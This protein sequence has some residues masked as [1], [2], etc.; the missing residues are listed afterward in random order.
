MAKKIQNV[1]DLLKDIGIDKEFQK[2]VE[3]VVQSRVISRKLL[4]LRNKTG[5]TQKELANKFK[6]TQSTISKIESKK[7]ADLTLGEIYKYCSVLN[8]PLELFFKPKDFKIVDSVKHHFFAMRNYLEQLKSLAKGDK[9]IQDGIQRFFSEVNI[10]LIEVLFDL[11]QDLPS[12]KK[13]SIELS[14]P[15]TSEKQEFKKA[16]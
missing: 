10:N 4:I 2:E 15:T 12:P 7:D 11:T 9:K 14:D 6:C 3:E 8:T 13:P 1:Q 5:L 16:I